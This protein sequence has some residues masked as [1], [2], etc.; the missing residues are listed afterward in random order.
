[1]TFVVLEDIASVCVC[2]VTCP[3]AL[4]S[5]HQ[6]VTC[7]GSS[8]LVTVRSLGFSGWLQSRVQGAPVAFRSNAHATDPTRRT[9][10]ALGEVILL[11]LVIISYL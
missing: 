5:C 1:M 4:L 6:L 10:S 7:P 8:C 9:I 2:L 11:Q 3:L